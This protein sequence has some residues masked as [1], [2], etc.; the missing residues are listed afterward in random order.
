[1]HENLEPSA[2]AAREAALRLMRAELQH[3][4]V[5]N[6]WDM[7]IDYCAVPLGIAKFLRETGIKNS[8]WLGTFW[9]RW[10]DAVRE[11]GFEPNQLQA[12]YD[13]DTLMEKLIGLTRELGHFPVRAELNMKS[14]R[15]TSF[16]WSLTFEKVF[17]PDATAGR[18]RF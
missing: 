9:G 6:S 1:M 16:P 5:V 18:P 3:R 10:S 14:R 2:W 15:D 8:D 11:A 7:L 17:W 13:A 12:A 4:P